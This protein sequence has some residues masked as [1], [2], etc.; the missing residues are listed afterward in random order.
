MKYFYRET[1]NTVQKGKVISCLFERKN[2][3]FLALIKFQ[4]AAAQ[5]LPNLLT[6]FFIADIIFLKICAFGGNNYATYRYAA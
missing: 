3:I 1:A 2:K 5:I 6:Y 4:F